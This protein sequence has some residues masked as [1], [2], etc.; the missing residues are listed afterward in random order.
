[1]NSRGRSTRL[2][3]PGLAILLLMTTPC[4]AVGLAP[5]F[6]FSLSECGFRDLGPPGT[7]FEREFDVRITTAR[8]YT[9]SP[10]STARTFQTSRHPLTRRGPW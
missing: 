2:A 1:M 4:R 10:T 6:E 9:S 7:Q 8:A 3:L 5:D